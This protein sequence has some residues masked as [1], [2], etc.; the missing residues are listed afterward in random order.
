[1]P[2][3]GTN[4]RMSGKLYL[5]TGP[6][7]TPGVSYGW[8]WTWTAGEALL[9]SSSITKLLP[10]GFILLFSVSFKSLTALTSSKA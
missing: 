9:T 1:M 2:S 7:I 4:G 5:N 8:T 6:G 10:K 3:Y